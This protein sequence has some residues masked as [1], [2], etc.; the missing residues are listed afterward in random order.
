MTI[1]EWDHS[2]SQILSGSHIVENKITSFDKERG[3]RK[4]Q[5]ILEGL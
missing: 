5:K 2:H 3:K 1:Q 4:Q